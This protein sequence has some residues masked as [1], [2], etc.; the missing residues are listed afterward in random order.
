MAFLNV[1]INIDDL[2]EDT[3]GDF[4]PVPEGEYTCQIKSADVQQTKDGSGQYIKIR[5]DIT[6]P[7]HSGRVVF[8]NINIQNKSAEAE[9]IGRG[10]LRSIMSALGL[11]TLQDTD[12]MIGGELSVKLSVREARTDEKTGKTYEASNE[13]KAYKAAGGAAPMSIAS[14]GMPKTAA[15]AAAPDKAAPPWAKK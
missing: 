2:P 8:T 4:S 10:Q 13:V 15:R 7:T 14:G 12:Q 11:V 6:G 3:G 5:L 9:R 1:P